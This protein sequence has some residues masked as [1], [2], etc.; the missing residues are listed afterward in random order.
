MKKQVITGHVFSSKKREGGTLVNIPS[1]IK[2]GEKSVKTVNDKG[3]SVLLVTGKGGEISINLTEISKN[4]EVLKGKS[5]TFLKN[6]ASED[7]QIHDHIVAVRN[8]LV[9]TGAI[10][11]LDDVIREVFK[12]V[13]VLMPGTVGAYYV[14]CSR[15][16]N[17]SGTPG[18]AATCA[19]SFGPEE[20]TMG[21]EACKNI[22]FLY[23]GNGTF[24][25][26][27]EVSDH[28]NAFIFIQDTLPFN[29]F[30]EEEVNKL[31]SHGICKVK[32][33]T[34]KDGSNYVDKSK[35][36]VSLDTYLIKA[37]TETRATPIQKRE[38][39]TSN[40]SSGGGLFLLIVLILIFIALIWYFTKKQRKP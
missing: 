12:D 30:S 11:H 40:E 18:C 26:L 23:D 28:T 15:D 2:K 8:H 5:S 33:V 20:G 17:F 25:F 14:G 10:S 34:Y 6:L 32:I 39:A 3:Q 37:N 24:H 35:D 36:F 31:R 4:L 16:T 29:G 19:G 7:R 13:Q 21:W 9:G 1:V 38:V 22:C 27:N